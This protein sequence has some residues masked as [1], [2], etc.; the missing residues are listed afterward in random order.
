M[1]SVLAIAAIL[2]LSCQ[3]QGEKPSD[4]NANQNLDTATFAGGCFWCVEAAF[5]QIK[6]VVSAVSGYAGG[7]KST[8]NYRLVSSGRTNHAE[9]VQ[10]FYDPE[11]IDYNT[12]LDI[13]FTAHDPTQVD[14][15][16][17]DIGRQYRSS[18]FYH[19]EEQKK[20][21]EA[22]FEELQPTLGKPIATELV[23]YTAFY[24]A[25]EYHQDFEKKNPNQS[26]V[27]AVS[28]P[29]IDRVARKFKHLLKE[30]EK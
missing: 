2:L 20:L 21:S 17:P 6:G 22:K 14:G 18:I 25:E 29:K 11:V 8:A 23:P 9:A 27:V 24:D 28:K 16:G 5:E 3:S 1:K 13:F 4:S 12:L 10:V 7:E 26:Y 19:N 30:E 15:Q